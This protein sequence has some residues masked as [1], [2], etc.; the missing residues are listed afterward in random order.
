MRD[1]DVLM[2]V[3]T[4]QAETQPCLVLDL[5][6]TLIR[7]DLLVESA[8]LYLSH[9]PSRI[10]SL[11]RLLGC[12]KAALKAGIAAVTPRDVRHLPYNAHV[13]DLIARARADGR[14]IYLASASNERYVSLVAE[15]IGADG[16]FASNDHLNLSSG[17]K[18][19]CLVTAFGEKNFDYAGNDHADLA[20]WKVARHG[21]AVGPSGSV[22]RALRASDLPVDILEKSHRNFRVWL[23]LLRVH[24]WAKNALVFVPLFLA[25]KFDVASIFSAVGA[26]FTFSFFASSIYIANDLVDIEDDRKHPIKN[27][28]P[29]A[30]GTVSILRG[31][32]VG[33]GLLLAGLTLATL[34]QPLLALVM[35]GYVVL[36]TAYTIVLKRKMLID[37]IVLASFYTLRILSG[38]A[39]IMV[40]VS[41]W[42]LA[43]SMFIFVSLALIKRYIELTMR[44][45][46]GIPDPSN[47]DYLK[48]DAAMVAALAV[49]AGFNAITVFALYINSDAVRHL[50]HRPGFL[51][52]VCLILMYWISR[53]LMLAHRKQI[54]NDPVLFALRDRASFVAFGMIIMCI[55]AAI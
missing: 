12:G 25:Q 3:P 29:L 47:R 19:H 1:E 30:A 14:K 44:I 33:V 21:F 10:F 32:V 54:D 23:R 49:G 13:L 18:A 17:A 4:V 35:L 5:D 28:R 2:I 50:Y 43:F 24:Q 36:T 34:I 7:T 15:H 31:L 39:A 11:F 22:Q 9:K 41:E 6:G 37:I 45:D 26:F 8:A 52:G 42:L 55:I 48:S 38:A 20:V 53:V 46:A 27:R 51:W 16:W 40:P